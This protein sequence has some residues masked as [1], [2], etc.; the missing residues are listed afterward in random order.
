MLP[1]EEPYLYEIAA[2]LR[3]GVEHRRVEES[4]FATIDDLAATPVS[5]H[6]LEKAKNQVLSSMAFESEKVTEI[7]HQLGYFATIAT[8]EQLDAVPGRV[9][10][11]SAAEVQRV[12]AECLTPERRTVGWFVPGNG[13]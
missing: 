8:L 3:D 1:T 11:V 4:L 5:D 2:T 9:A 12:I 6:A 13:A 7:G 10:A